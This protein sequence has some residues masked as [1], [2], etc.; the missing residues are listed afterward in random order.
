MRRSKSSGLPK[1]YQPGK[2]GK[3]IIDPNTKDTYLLNKEI[4]STSDG[5]CRVYRALHSESMENDTLIPCGHVTLKTI[6]KN[7]ENE[8]VE[9]QLEAHTSF[10][11]P[12]GNLIAVKNYFDTNEVLCV[13]LPYMSEGSLRYIL[14]TRTQKILSEDCIAIVLKES[15]LGLKDIH[16]IRRVHTT[17]NA[18]DILVHIGDSNGEIKIKLAFAASVYNSENINTEE[19]EGGSSSSVF[20]DLKSISKWGAAPEVYEKDNATNGPK[21]DIW[22]LGITA[23]ELGYGELPVKNREDLDCIIKKIREKKKLPKSLEKL[24]KKKGKVKKALDL[25]KR[26]E[27]VFSEEFENMVIECLNEE[28]EKRPTADQ[29]LNYPFFTKQRDMKRFE[30]FVLNSENN[31]DPTSDN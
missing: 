19:E 5:C 27:K 15:L 23:L 25:I 29:L 21:S 11:N 18:G 16:L 20:L 26:K 1:D 3:T 31:S 4:G 7:H 14:S 17:F 2:V 28:P 6:N 24:L 10:T 13:S 30:Q 22:L 8:C 9:L 12:R